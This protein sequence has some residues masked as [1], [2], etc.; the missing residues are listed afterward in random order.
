[1]QTR[2]K[3]VSFHRMC[4]S[5]NIDLNLNHIFQSPHVSTCSDDCT[6]MGKKDILNSQIKIGVNLKAFA[7]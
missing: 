2:E 7:R 3:N 6:A 1:M 5:K 4:R